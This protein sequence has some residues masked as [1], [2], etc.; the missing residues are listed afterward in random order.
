MSQAEP[1]YVQEGHPTGEEPH[2]K[3]VDVISEIKTDDSERNYSVAWATETHDHGAEYK[4]DS[5]KKRTPDDTLR[6]VGASRGGKYDIVPHYDGVPRI[7][8][9]HPDFGDIKWTEKATEL[10]IMAG[11]FEY[12]PEERGFLDRTKDK[13]GL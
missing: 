8:Y 13:L 7:R 5:V 9:H 12:D 4:V 1:L 11:R 10:I 3:L 6:I 2:L